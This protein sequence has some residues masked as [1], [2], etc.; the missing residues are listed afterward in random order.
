MTVVPIR[1]GMPTRPAA[2]VDASAVVALLVD[3]GPVGEWVSEVAEGRML[4]A[5]DLMPFEVTNVLRRNRL[6]GLIDE[7]TANLAHADMLDMVI[8]L[9]P[10]YAVA[11]RVW[12]LREN[13]TAYD[14]AYVAI[15]EA[16]GIPLIT[17]DERLARASGPT[18]EFLTP[19]SAA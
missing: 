16:R 19:V 15:A 4:F 11:E 18:C 14:A 5:S 3:S 7:T 10:Y 6:A 12:A 1:R 9:D 13:V 17:L 8:F 2:V